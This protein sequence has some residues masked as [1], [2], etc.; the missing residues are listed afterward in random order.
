MRFSTLS[1][2]LFALLLSNVSVTHANE[3]TPPSKAATPPA[4]AATP[5]S[6]AATPPAKAATPPAKAATA[7]PAAPAASPAKPGSPTAPPA[8]AHPEVCEVEMFGDFKLPKLAPGQHAYAFVAQDSDCLAPNAHILGHNQLAENGQLFI[9]VFSRWGADLTLCVAIANDPSQ[10]STYY[11]KAPGKF[12]AEAA[13]EVMFPK[14][15]FDL[16]PG[17][18]HVFPEGKPPVPVA[19][20]AHK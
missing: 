13:G 15:T 16:K 4:K 17:K 18:K 8:P 9:E 11:G 7:S 3:A 5:P 20:A 1:A 2:P 6:K 10:P 12:H 14:I 19:P